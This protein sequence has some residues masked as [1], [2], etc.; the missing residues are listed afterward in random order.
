MNCGCKSCKNDMKKNKR[1]PVGLIKRLTKPVKMTR[2]A[3]Q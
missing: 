3:F 2:K 1:M